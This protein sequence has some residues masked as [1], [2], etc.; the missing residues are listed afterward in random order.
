MEK[1]S[2]T[3]ISESDCVAVGC[4]VLPGGGVDPGESTLTAAIREMHEETG[5]TPD[6]ETGLTT[7][8]FA[9]WESTCQ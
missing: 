6:S 3:I 7:K 4:R 2:L 5:L 8:P 1:L 9:M